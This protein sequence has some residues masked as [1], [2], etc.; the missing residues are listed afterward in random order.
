MREDDASVTILLRPCPSGGKLV[1]RHAYEP[2]RGKTAA[3]E[4]LENALMKVSVKLPLPR[5]LVDAALPVAFNYISETRK[6]E[7]MGVISGSYPW[8][9]GSRGLPYY[10]S[11]C[12][13]LLEE[14][15][16]DWLEVL[17]P[18]G[19]REPCVWRARK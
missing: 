7:G 11:L 4:R 16:C 3:R 6:P 17:P 10:C 8:T 1:R 18:G 12:T 2:L 13:A 19:D 9:G 14:S 15:G 5:F